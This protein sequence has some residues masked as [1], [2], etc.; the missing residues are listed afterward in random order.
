M[1]W[2]VWILI[3][4]EV[5]VMKAVNNPICAHRN[6][7]NHSTHSSNQVVEPPRV[8]QP[9]MGGVV[10]KHNERVLLG[11]NYCDCYCHENWIP[12]QIGK[13]LSLIHI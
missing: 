12:D 4:V 9:I 10:A 2:Y 7:N 1:E 3:L 6:T 11:G 8:K 13:C 5:V